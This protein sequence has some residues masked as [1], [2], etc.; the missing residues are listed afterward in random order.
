M[1]HGLI[2]CSVKRLVFTIYLNS[3][4]DCPWVQ[5]PP[6]QDIMVSG[7]IAGTSTKFRVVLYFADNSA[8]YCHSYSCQL[9]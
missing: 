5:Y 8:L 7:I 3:R 4:M 2:L 6:K 9:V 1:N